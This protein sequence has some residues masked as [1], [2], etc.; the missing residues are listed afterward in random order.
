MAVPR[1]E[2]S[3]DRA[4]QDRLNSTSKKDIRSLWILVV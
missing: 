4:D 2:S 3:K 1:S